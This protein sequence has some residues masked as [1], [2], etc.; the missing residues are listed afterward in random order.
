MSF[1]P[2]FDVLCQNLDSFIEELSQE[3]IDFSRSVNNLTEILKHRFLKEFGF[4]IEKILP[5]FEKMPKDR[6]KCL[7]HEEPTT[8]REIILLL[9]SINVRHPYFPSK[10]LEKVFPFCENL[11]ADL[12]SQGRWANV[13]RLMV[14]PEIFKLQNEFAQTYNKL[15]E[16]V[17]ND[18][19]G[20]SHKK[21]IDLRNRKRCKKIYKLLLEKLAAHN[22]G[23]KQFSWRGPDFDDFYELGFSWDSLDIEME[24][25]FIEILEKSKST[26]ESYTRSYPFVHIDDSQFFSSIIDSPETF[27]RLLQ[28]VEKPYV[29][30][31]ERLSITR[32][33]AHYFTFD[34]L[35]YFVNTDIGENPVT[36]YQ[37]AEKYRRPITVTRL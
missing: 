23:L 17:W 33:T 16:V 24:S 13:R 36:V 22:F 1:I 2:E 10:Q 29:K 35:T 15:P 14:N 6:V 9:K 30:F 8:F 19:S 31:L 3:E 5:N 18:Q 7:R 32:A 37:K 20:K 11:Y 4:D 26:R 27:F 34:E 28:L 12:I 25:K 21:S